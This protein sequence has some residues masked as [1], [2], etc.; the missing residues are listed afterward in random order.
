MKFIDEARIEVCGGNGGDGCASFRREKFI[1]K[2][3]PDGGDGGRGGSVCAVADRN[4][5]TL[6]DFRY[7]PS[8]RQRAAKM[9]AAPIVMVPPAR[10]SPAVPGGTVISDEES[11][12]KLVDISAHGQQLLAKGGTGGLGNLHFKSSI[13]RAP[14]QFTKGE[15]G[16]RRKLHRAAGAGRCRPAGLP[17]RRQVHADRSSVQCA[18]AYWPTIPSRRCIRTSASYAWS[19]AKICHCRRAGPDRRR[20]ARERASATSFLR[21]L[22]RTVFCSTYRRRCRPEATIDP[23]RGARA[24]AAELKKYDQ[25]LYTQAPLVRAEQDRSGAADERDATFV[26]RISAAVANE[27]ARFMRFPPPPARLSRT[28]V[29]R[30]QRFLPDNATDPNEAEDVDDGSR[31]SAPRRQGQRVSIGSPPHAALSS[32]LAAAGHERGPRARSRGDRGW[33]AQIAALRKLGKQVI[34]VSS[35]A[36]AEGMQRLGWTSRPQQ[37]H[38]L[39]AAA[40]VGQMGLAQAYETSF[41]ERGLHTAQVLLTHA[42]LADRARYLNARSTLFALL[43]LG[44]VPVVNENDTV[45]TDEIKFGDNDTLGALVTNLVEADV[46]VILTDQRGLFSSDPRRDPDATLIES[47]NAG[48]PYARNHRGGRWAAESR[49]GGMITKVLAAKRAARS[50]AHTTIASGREPD[51]LVR[52]ARGEAVGTQLTAAVQVLTARKQ[53]LADH[54]QLKGRIVI[55]AGAARALRS[56]GQAACYRSA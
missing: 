43:E 53:W 5:N 41:R 2:G 27:G 16:E 20:C 19:R 24:I 15:A 33:A 35:G 14:R 47:A 17:K 6:I 1:P 32:R 31:R 26:E 49:A 39:Q 18:A 46:L 3:G 45:V 44:V 4:I 56:G 21:H 8:I 48:D 28:D 22:A 55:D 36:I 52:L 9:A 29:R 51:V 54:L 50:G 10:T 25:N 12:E 23:V 13:N 34:L 30:W 40:A 11:G 38:E 42:D 7:V 37:F